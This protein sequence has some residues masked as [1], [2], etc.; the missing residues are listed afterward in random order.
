[1]IRDPSSSFSSFLEKL[2]QSHFTPVIL[3]GRIGLLKDF[4]D[5]LDFGKVWMRLPRVPPPAPKGQRNRKYKEW[6]VG[7]LASSMVTNENWTNEGIVSCSFEL[8]NMII[9]KLDGEG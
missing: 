8:A 9:K 4:R 5:T 2:S 3:V 6:L 1:M 7:K